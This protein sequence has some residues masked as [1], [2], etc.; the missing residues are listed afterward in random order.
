M[1]SSIYKK[2]YE[3]ID[4]YEKKIGVSNFKMDK[5]K[6]E[7]LNI[8]KRTNQH[9]KKSEELKKEKKINKNTKIDLKELENALNKIPKAT[10]IDLKEL[11]DALNKIPKVT[12]IDLKELDDA[13]NQIPKVTK[14]DLKELDDA[15]NKIPK[16]TKIQMKE[17]EG[18]LPKLNVTKITQKRKR[19]NEK[20]TSQQIKRVKIKE[21]Y[22]IWQLY[23]PETKR[24]VKK[25]NKT[26][27]N[28]IKKYGL[29]NLQKRIAQSI[30]IKRLK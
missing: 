29:D 30:L 20:P 10:K 17:L 26:G 7:L 15:L 18:V 21:K 4:E 16:V 11:D 3:V 12:K 13:L 24:W 5:I 9:K 14:I 28:L 6:R 27:M 25:D 22:D 1:D 8:E 23:N 2:Y 19:S